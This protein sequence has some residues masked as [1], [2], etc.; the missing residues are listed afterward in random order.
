MSNFDW[1]GP[2]KSKVLDALSRS[3]GL[4]EFTPDGII[5]N[6][7]E[8][9][10]RVVGYTLAEIK[11]KHHR[12]FVEPGYAASPAYQA[13][14]D[15]LRRGEFDAAEYRRIGKG[16]REIWIQA[17]YNPVK[18]ARGTVQKIVK[19]ATDIT[20]QKNQHAEAQGLINGISRAQ[21][22]DRVHPNRRNHRGQREFPRRGR[23]P[24]R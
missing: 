8:N 2:S 7:N 24:A 1:F 15:K 14:W 17:S 6:A 5:L 13:F 22:V 21:A 20:R 16:G 19:Q 11:G 23:L 4:I 9:F 12:I 10:C 18:T 3:L